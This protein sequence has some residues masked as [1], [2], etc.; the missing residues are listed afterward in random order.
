MSSGALVVYPVMRRLIYDF[1]VS[2]DGYV[3]DR[4]GSIDWTDPD[5]E[6]H[7]FHNDRFRP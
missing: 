5:A 1:G 4:D 3:N 6:H 7:R 2:V